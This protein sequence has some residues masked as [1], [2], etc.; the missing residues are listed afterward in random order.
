M[1]NHAFFI[2]AEARG[3][4]SRVQSPEKKKQ[5]IDDSKNFVYAASQ[6]LNYI[7]TDD[8]LSNPIPRK[9]FVVLPLIC[10][11]KTHIS[12][13]IKAYMCLAISM[14]ESPAEGNSKRLPSPRLPKGEDQP[15][16]SHIEQITHLLRTSYAMCRDASKLETLNC[17]QFKDHTRVTIKAIQSATNS[18]LTDEEQ[19][20]PIFTASCQYLESSVGL[21]TAVRE[22]KGKSI[23]N[24][25]DMKKQ[26][27]WQKALE[28]R[29]E[30]IAAFKLLA[31]SVREMAKKPGQNQN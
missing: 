26:E 11:A 24:F 3:I 30:W 1:H 18:F 8:L 12:R 23:Q 16:H 6:Y 9:R 25:N 27:L 31:S 10:A 2:P 4:A 13:V 22:Y 20:K 21:V 7:C 17:T 19:R 14:V 15:L 29:S 28:K 5:I